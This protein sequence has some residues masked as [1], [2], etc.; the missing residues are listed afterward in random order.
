M[1][2]MLDELLLVGGEDRD[3]ETVDV[4]RV[5]TPV[6]SIGGRPHCR[7]NTTCVARADATCCVQA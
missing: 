7:V 3:H 5:V 6:G 1:A 2:R 4:G